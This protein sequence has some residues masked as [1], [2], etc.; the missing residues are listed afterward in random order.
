MGTEPQLGKM[1]KFWRWAGV[2]VTYD[3]NAFNA[4]AFER[5]KMVHV[6]NFMCVSAQ[7][8][9]ISLKNQCTVPE[10]CSS[11]GGAQRAEGWSGGAGV[12][13]VGG[14]RLVF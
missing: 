8:R 10:G 6:V 3:A 2:T 9:E 11:Q 12:P 5:L 7:A 13:R 14:T 1:E 4:A